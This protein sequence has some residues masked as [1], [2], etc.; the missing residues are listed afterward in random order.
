MNMPAQVYPIK[1]SKHDI[2]PLKHFQTVIL[3]FLNH[4]L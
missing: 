1:S 4:F 2:N 3:I